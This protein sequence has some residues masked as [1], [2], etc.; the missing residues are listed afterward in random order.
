VHGEAT[1]IDPTAQ[2]VAKTFESHKVLNDFDV[3]PSVRVAGPGEGLRAHVVAV[4]DVRSPRRVS[5]SKPLGFPMEVHAIAEHLHHGT[6]VAR[7]DLRAL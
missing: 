4:R 5:R 3:I 2:K 6:T 7:C 1:K